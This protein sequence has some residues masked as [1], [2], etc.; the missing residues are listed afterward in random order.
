MKLQPYDL[1]ISDTDMFKSICVLHA[2]R[3]LSGLDMN[4]YLSNLNETMELV[5]DETKKNELANK[6]YEEGID[7]YIE[8]C[9]TIRLVTESERPVGRYY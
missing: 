8:R 2:K 5:V 1:P 3:I 9:E 4:V 6:L 7:E